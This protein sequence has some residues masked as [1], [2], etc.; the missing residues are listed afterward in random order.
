MSEKDKTHARVMADLR[1]KMMGLDKD[2]RVVL[3]VLGVKVEGKPP[4]N[5]QLMTGYKKA[6]VQFHPDRVKQKGGGDEDLY[7]ELMAEE[8]FKLVTLHRDALRAVMDGG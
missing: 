3:Q 2:P 5:V 1:Q 8:T 4:S 6:L 7:S